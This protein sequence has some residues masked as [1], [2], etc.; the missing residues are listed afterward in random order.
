MSSDRVFGVVPREQAAASSG[1]DFMQAVLDGGLPSPPFAQTA[2]V[3]PTVL[4]KGRVVFEGRPSARFYNPMGMVHGGW[5]AML[6]D[7]VM[8]CAVHTSLA[9]GQAYTTLEMSTTFVKAVLE[10]TGVVR[11]E[12]V[13][14]H[15]GSRVASAEGKIY[16]G[17]GTLLAHGTESCLIMSL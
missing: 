16:D 13:L 3:W 4:E 10:K 12:G 8:G 2:D 7:T 15:R 17:S 11:A 1:L 5:L 14:L 9:A 6:L